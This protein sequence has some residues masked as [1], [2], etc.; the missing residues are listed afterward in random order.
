MISQRLLD[1][2]HEANRDLCPVIQHHQYHT[3]NAGVIGN[4][5]DIFQCNET[6]EIIL[7]VDHER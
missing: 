2:L 1:T 6:R 5:R 7:K 3:D 4:K